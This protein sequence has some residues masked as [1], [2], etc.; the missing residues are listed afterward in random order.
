MCYLNV[1]QE[2]AAQNQRRTSSVPDGSHIEHRTG[3][4]FVKE[5]NKAK[6]VKGA[7]VR[8]IQDSGTNVRRIIQA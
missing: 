6:R 8:S 1:P 2:D 5:W 4:N 7:M 3:R